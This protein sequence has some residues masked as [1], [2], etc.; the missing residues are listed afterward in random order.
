MVLLGY[1]PSIARIKQWQNEAHC[2][3]REGEICGF[4]LIEDREGEIEVVLYYGD[5]LP[6]H[7]RMQFQALFE[8]FLYRLDVEITRFPLI[9]C[10]N[11][12]RQK[13]ATVVERVR[14]GKPFENASLGYYVFNPTGPKDISGFSGFFRAQWN[15]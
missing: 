4:R 12:H 2:E 8:E 9:V 7:G 1:M 11:G 3:M 15:F 6:P 13:R 10:A 14:D 5:Q